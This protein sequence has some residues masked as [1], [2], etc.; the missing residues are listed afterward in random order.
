[1]PLQDRLFILY[2]KA[3]Q[4]LAEFKNRLVNNPEMEK[5]LV[6]SGTALG[7]GAA[8]VGV[9]GLGTAL[10]GYSKVKSDISTATA[11]AGASFLDRGRTAHLSGARAG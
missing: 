5:G 11:T 9:I 3:S 10:W 8:V 6:I 7:I 1:M 2:Y 4:D